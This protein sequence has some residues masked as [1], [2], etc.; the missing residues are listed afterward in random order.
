[1]AGVVPPRRRL[2]PALDEAVSLSNSQTMFPDEVFKEFEGLLLAQ[3]PPVRDLSPSGSSCGRSRHISAG[4]LS[5]A[6]SLSRQLLAI[7][8]VSTV[9]TALTLGRGMA[10]RCAVT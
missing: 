3:I 8:L 5:V 2:Q 6:P 1:M 9:A 7:M 10:P 4:D